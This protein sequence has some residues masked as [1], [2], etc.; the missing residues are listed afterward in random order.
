MFII[1]IKPDT[2]MHFSQQFTSLQ[3]ETKLIPNHKAKTKVGFQCIVAKIGLGFIRSGVA[4]LC[5]A[6]VSIRPLWPLLRNI[7]D[8]C[9]IS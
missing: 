5:V 1:P 9:L 7:A 8:S 6:C 3:A 4:K 2:A